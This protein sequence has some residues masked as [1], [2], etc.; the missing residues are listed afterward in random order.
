MSKAN[1]V[2][3]AMGGLAVGVLLGLIVATLIGESPADVASEQDR[4]PIEN[5]SPQEGLAS[6]K[7]AGDGK[8]AGDWGP[9]SQLAKEVGPGSR[10]LKFATRLHDEGVW[11]SGW[12]WSITAPTNPSSTV[13]LNLTAIGEGK[14]YLEAIVHVHSAGDPMWVTLVFKPGEGSRRALATANRNERILAVGE[15]INLTPEEL[16]RLDTLLRLL[17]LVPRSEV[18]SG[19]EQFIL[20]LPKRVVERFPKCLAYYATPDAAVADSITLDGDGPAVG[21]MLSKRA[22]VEVAFM[23]TEPSGCGYKWEYLK[24]GPWWSVMIHDAAY[25]DYTSAEE[26]RVADGTTWL[27]WPRVTVEEIDRLRATALR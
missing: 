9:L 17:P 14:V 11:D 6:R 21:I 3:V 27:P 7:A 25:E 8:A 20:R 5:E 19:L 12:Y 15:A 22:V 2:I 4:V 24:P 18:E 23:A 26:P 10:F 16:T 13:K 1:I